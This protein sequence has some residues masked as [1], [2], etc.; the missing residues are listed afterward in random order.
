[1]KKS[2]TNPSLLIGIIGGVFAFFILFIIAILSFQNNHGGTDSESPENATALA[3][4][5]PVVSPPVIA[6]STEPKLPV[7][8][9]S[10][11]KSSWVGSVSGD[12]KVLTIKGIDYAFRWC[13]AG[14][15]MMGSPDS[16]LGRYDSETQHE[17]TLT[18]GFWIL[19]TEVTQGM[20]E[21]VT[22][23]NPSRFK[24]NKFPVENVSRNDCQDFIEML[25]GLSEAVPV[26]LKFSL[27]TE[28][29]WEYACRAGTTTSLNN[30]TA[31]TVEKGKCNN[32]DEV[33][34]YDANSKSKTHEVG[35]KKENNWGLYDMHGNVWEW[36]LDWYDK[37]YASGSAI[38]PT[39]SGSGTQRV[40]RGGSWGR[41]ARGCRS[42]YRGIGTPDLKRSSFGCRP[43]L[44]SIAP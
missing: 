39:G 42:A 36:C 21:S 8:N 17:V 15:F 25:N 43:C 16:E 2:A 6:S 32:L 7:A 18:Q 44:I 23:S 9:S 26:G 30:E 28:A 33:C 22:G 20:W 31:V 14:K 37:R 38:D 4:T 1:M 41:D 19:E 35:L 34:W 10:E 3:E 12:R 5:V 40:Y 27:P 24:G 11:S 29:Q 13:P